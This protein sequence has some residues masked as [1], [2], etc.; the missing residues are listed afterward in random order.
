[1]SE[2][3]IETI[4]RAIGGDPNEPDNIAWLQVW[5][6]SME[7]ARASTKAPPT[8]AEDFASAINRHSAEIGSNTPDFILGEYLVGCLAAF[9]GA[10]NKR[11]TWHG[12]TSRTC[13][14]PFMPA[15][16]RSDPYGPL[17]CESHGTDCLASE[18]VDSR[19]DGP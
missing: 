19:E 4:T 11:E 12:R 1:M 15:P 7:A 8:L 2:T 3:L 9:D 14:G 10:V 5:A 6:D 18:V 16:G 17:A 13:S